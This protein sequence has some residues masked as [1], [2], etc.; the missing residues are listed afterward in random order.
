MNV[1]PAE[2]SAAR[3]LNLNIVFH[4]LFIFL[5]QDFYSISSPLIEGQ[6]RALLDDHSFRKITENCRV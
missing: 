6:V 4:R 1:A 3:K 5:G 2:N